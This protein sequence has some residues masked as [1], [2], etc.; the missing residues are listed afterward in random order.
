MIAALIAEKLNK[1]TVSE[2]HRM[3]KPWVG[4]RNRLILDDEK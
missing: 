4:A 3:G 1:V 2:R